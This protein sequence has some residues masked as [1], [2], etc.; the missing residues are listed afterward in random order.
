MRHRIGAVAAVVTGVVL[1]AGHAALYGHWIMDDAAITFGY[2]RSVA[3]GLGPV[4][5]PGAEPVEGYSNPVWLL[6]L[7]LGSVL[8]LFDHGTILGVPDYVLFPKALALACCAGVLTLFYF[9]AKAITA[10]PR[11]ATLLAGGALAATPSFVIWCFSGLENSVYALFVTAIAAV[12]VRAIASDRLLR[13]GTAALAGVLA[14]GAALSRPDGAIYAG[15]FSLVALVLLRR[16]R[17]RATLVAAAV[18][19]A[20]F[21]VPFGGYVAWR[22]SVFGLLVPNTAVAKSQP[23]PEIED[24]GTAGNLVVYAG[25]PIVLLVVGCLAAVL[26]RPVPERARFTGLLVPLALAVV[27]FCVLLP[28]WM[29]EY[30]FATP[31]WVL[32]ALTGAT[33]VTA[34]WDTVRPR[35]KVLLAGGLVIAAVLSLTQ[36]VAAGRAFR[37]AVKTP[38]CVVVERDARTLNG[39]ADILG[40]DDL[41]AGVI[42]LGGVALVSRLRLVDLAGLGDRRIARYLGAGDLPGFR[43]YVLTEA[44]PDF[45]TL[46]GTWDRTLGLPADPR[47]AQAYDLV[48]HS[49]PAEVLSLATDNVGFWVRKDR[50]PDPATLDEMRAYAAARVGSLPARNAAAPRRAC[51]PVLRRGQT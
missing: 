38:M 20:A 28:D 49:P 4:L 8:G 36:L 12:L 39:L 10:R 25:W 34:V 13:P 23:L 17:L 43:D 26:T 45:I 22:W 42:D 30:R 27:A 44:K 47:F 50:V 7:A 46:I 41:S 51:G 9:T 37:A 40:G 18:S 32:G 14:A 1:L 16:E 21:A 2:A 3:D 15:A 31:V 29:G 48:Y 5:Q 11:T 19:V 35:S 6:L 24:L 33:T